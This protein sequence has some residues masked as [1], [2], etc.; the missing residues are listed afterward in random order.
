MLW[1][2]SSSTLSWTWWQVTCRRFRP[3]RVFQAGLLLSGCIWVC[4]C[5]STS[6]ARTRFPV[7]VMCVDWCVPV[8]D[9]TALIPQTSLLVYTP[10]Q[11]TCRPV[12]W[13]TFRRKSHDQTPSPPR[14]LTFFTAFGAVAL[15]EGFYDALI[16]TKSTVQCSHKNMQ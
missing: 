12:G 13:M 4:V 3:A 6:Y 8:R 11:R 10:I 2:S 9:L 15:L 5:V 7:C 14:P 1:W 16:V